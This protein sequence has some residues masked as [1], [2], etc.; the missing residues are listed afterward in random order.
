M[1]DASGRALGAVLLQKC[2]Q[3]DHP[4]ALASR[5]L[6]RAETRDNGHICMRCQL[7]SV[8]TQRSTSQ[9]LIDCGSE[10]SGPST[11]MLSNQY[12]LHLQLLPQLLQSGSSLWQNP[13]VP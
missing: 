6:S 7:C 11:S 10:S 2:G 1:T 12:C 9:S 13:K 8:M 3:E 5:K 4:I